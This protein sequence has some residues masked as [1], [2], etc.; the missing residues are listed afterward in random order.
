MPPAVLLSSPS[1]YPLPPPPRRPIGKKTP[2]LFL[3]LYVDLVHPWSDCRNSPPCSPLPPQTAPEKAAQCCAVSPVFPSPAN[4]LQLTPDHQRRLPTPS[5]RSLKAVGEFGAPPAA[6]H[7]P[8]QKPSG[9]NSSTDQ[10]ALHRCRETSPLLA[11]P[12]I[13]TPLRQSGQAMSV[14]PDQSLHCS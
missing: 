9:L 3:F 13:P 10:M 14:S 6:L 4:S 5:R 12:A 8:S 2:S 11:P 7:P 1:P